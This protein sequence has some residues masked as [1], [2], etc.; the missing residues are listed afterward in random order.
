MP[1]ASARRW[2]FSL[3]KDRGARRSS[4]DQPPPRGEDDCGGAAL[5]AELLE[6]GMHVGLGGSGADLKAGRMN[7]EY[8]LTIDRGQRYA[9]FVAIARE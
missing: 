6:D 3:P 1:R 9:G 7:L 5:D 8:S 4:A 2:E